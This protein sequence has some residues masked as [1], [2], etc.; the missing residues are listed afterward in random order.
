[1]KETKV[2]VGKR[3]GK[4]LVTKYLGSIGAKGIHWECKCD[5]G[6]TAILTN[7]KL[8][9]RGTDSC[10]CIRLEV[11]KSGY[12]EITG[13]WYGQL[14]RNAIARDL[15]FNL[16][17]KYL[18][19]L[20][21]KQNYKC[22]LT[23]LPLRIERVVRKANLSTASLDRIDN[24]LGYIKG[25]VQ[26]V[27]KNVNMMKY[28]FNQDY[29]IYM[30]KLITDYYLYNK[31]NDN[32]N[33]TKIDD[34]KYEVNDGKYKQIQKGA[35]ERNIIFNLSLEFLNQ[36]LQKQNYKCAISGIPIN[37]NPYQGSKIK[38]TASLDRIDSKI[39]YEENNV[40]WI[41]KHINKMK[42]DYNQ[43]YFIDLCIAIAKNNL[44]LESNYEQTC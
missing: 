10:G 6:K 40:Q 4:L 20:F 23:G 19:E 8:L 31:N 30:C 38:S 43:N 26:F 42:W 2:E 33:I 9:N 16:D 28:T 7:F 22:A 39:G 34:I 32:N 11:I 41:H 35:K 1:M 18:D 29:L 44:I 5:C 21:K 14:G 17:I 3:F 36:L 24:N 13:Q 27:H 25:N 15:E 37:L 12:G